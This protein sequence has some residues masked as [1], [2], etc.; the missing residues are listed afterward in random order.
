MSSAFLT[1]GLNDLPVTRATYSHVGVRD[2][3][4]GTWP[5]CF[6]PLFGADMGVDPAL[7]SVPIADRFVS[8]SI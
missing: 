1:I 8:N 5:G 4:G 7:D 6:F 3:T 2:E